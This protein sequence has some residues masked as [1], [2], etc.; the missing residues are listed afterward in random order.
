VVEISVDS[1]MAMEMPVK[2]QV[3]YQA[4]CDHFLQF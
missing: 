1:Q 4:C 3:R 2:P